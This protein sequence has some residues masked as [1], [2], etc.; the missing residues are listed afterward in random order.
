MAQ[1]TTKEAH[2]EKEPKVYEI[3][4]LL[5]PTLA[6]ESVPDE[7]NAIRNTVE[8]LHGLM[9]ADGGTPELLELSYPMDKKVANKKIVYESAYFGWVKF[10][11]RPDALPALKKALEEN[12]KIIRFL[13]ITTVKENTVLPK[14]FGTT[15]RKREDHAPAAGG[16]AVILTPAEIDKTVDELISTATV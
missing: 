10:H 2:I 1:P 9:I 5:V 3:G 4:F 16:S 6:T 13:L 14:R 7:I 11:A 12:P 8:S 15:P